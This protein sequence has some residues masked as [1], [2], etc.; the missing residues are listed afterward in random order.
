MTRGNVISE[1]TARLVSGTARCAVRPSSGHAGQSW[2][3]HGAGVRSRLQ[4]HI[5]VEGPPPGGRGRHAYWAICLLPTSLDSQA[6]LIAADLIGD[7]E[8]A[9]RLASAR[10]HDGDWGRPAFPDRCR[11]HGR[12]TG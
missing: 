12:V 10:G 4:R 5:P 6:R 9:I 7:A 3:S 11:I 2:F 1:L 8:R